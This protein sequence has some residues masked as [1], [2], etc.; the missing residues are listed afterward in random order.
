MSKQASVTFQ[1][2]FEQGDHV[3]PSRHRPRIRPTLDPFKA[4]QSPPKIQ[5]KD[6]YEKVLSASKNP[7]PPKQGNVEAKALGQRIL[8]RDETQAVGI[9]SRLPT[10]M[11][12]HPLE[13][14][15]N[16]VFGVA[17]LVK[18]SASSRTNLR[19]LYQRVIEIL[20]YTDSLSQGT[21]RP[22]SVGH[23]ALGNKTCTTETNL[24]VADKTKDTKSN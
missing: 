8:I 5:E 20:Q 22:N 12:P 15:Y 24:S 11:K 2:S 6:I 23:V 3:S 7:H 16:N 21:Q 17:V 13:G 4:Q 14:C 18:Q 9:A 19:K 1:S 10:W